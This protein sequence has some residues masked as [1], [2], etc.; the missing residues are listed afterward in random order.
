MMVDDLR[1]KTKE[2]QML[3]VTRD[4]S[5]VFDT[6]DKAGDKGSGANESAMLEALA[7]QREALHAK[8]NVQVVLGHV[9]GGGLLFMGSSAA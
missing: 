6:K 9:M 1:E 3:H 7:K 4:F 8:V 5:S 2:L